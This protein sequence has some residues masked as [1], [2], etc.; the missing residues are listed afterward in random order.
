[1]ATN[2]SIPQLDLIGIVVEDMARSLAF[3]RQLPLD[4]PTDADTQPHAEATLP[5]GMR[6]AWDTLET[7]RSFDPDF[8]APSGSSRIGLAFR[9]PNLAAVDA[10]Y[11]QLV[12]AGCHGHKA[13]WDA[14]WG[15]RNALIHDPDGNNVDLFDPLPSGG[16]PT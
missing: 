7:V 2:T 8:Q 13:P 12:A 14:G 3:Y 6:L 10:T 5:G 15:Q 11:E 4:I 9:L 16:D 1:M